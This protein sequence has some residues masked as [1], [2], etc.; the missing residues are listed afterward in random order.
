[1]TKPTPIVVIGGGEH[2]RVVID[3]LRTRPDRFTVMGFLDPAPCDDTV[4]RFATPRLGD[5]AAIARLAEDVRFVLG[6]GGVGSQ[7]R[8][9]QIA[10]T[11]PSSRIAPAIVHAD[12]TVSPSAAIDAGAVVCARAVVATG[13]RVGRHAIVN[14]GAI[15]EHDVVVGEFAH[16]GPGAL[17][18]GGA[19]IGERAYL[20][21]GSCVRDHVTVGASA[22]V[23]M[24]AVVTTSVAVGQMVRG[25]PA[26]GDAPKR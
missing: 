19:F 4:S 8:R 22:F 14:H 15:V 17:I 9:A 20:G 24:G 21:L 13:A 1:M 23:A 10:A 18:G 3:T 2:G 7:D 5:D 11:L 16:V 26:R 25:I 12:A 6:V